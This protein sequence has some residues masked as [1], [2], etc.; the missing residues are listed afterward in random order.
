MDGRV[1]TDAIDPDF[2]DRQP[3]QFIESYDSLLGRRPAEPVADTEVGLDEVKKRLKDLG[4]I[5]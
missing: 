4:Y 2:L 1:L 5:T 3:V